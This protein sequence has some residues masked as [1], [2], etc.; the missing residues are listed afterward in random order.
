MNTITI[1]SLGPGGG[2]CLTVAAIE[3]MR[4]A[5]KLILRTDHTR[6]ADTIR[7]Q[8]MPYI[9]L[10][11]LYETADDFDALNA[12]L[13]SAV[14]AEAE[15][16]PIVY[17]VLD[18]QRDQS[19]QLL[20]EHG[21]P[22]RFVPGIGLFDPLVLAHP[23]ARVCPADTLPDS[24]GDEPL[25]IVEL[26]NAL[27]AG[28]VKLRLID[29]FGASCPCQWYTPDET[30]ERTAITIR[31]EDL[32]R[33]CAYDHTA[34]LYIAPQP[35]TEKERWTVNDLVRIMRILRQPGG[36]PWDRAQTHESLRPYL[37]EE[38][39]EVTQAIR[40]EDWLH[41]ADELGDVLLQVIFQSN[42]G[43]QYGT[44]NLSDITT[45]ICSKMIRRHPH[46]FSDVKA[47]TA[48]DVSH[49]WETI[50]RS[51]RGQ[52]S[53]AEVIDDI[54]ASLPPI[55]RAQKIQRKA[56][57]AGLLPDDSE[58]ALERISESLEV[59]RNTLRHGKD[60]QEALGELLFSCT[61]AARVIGKDS[62]TALS[63]ATDHFCKCVQTWE[64]QKN[65]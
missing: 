34:A 59:L 39:Y 44:L 28:E 8:G 38:A 37:I 43:E 3:A 63:D 11:S 26:D 15:I 46:I 45:A 12:A 33:Q 58:A 54:P 56:Q 61:N 60:T 10:D 30:P 42:I 64:K 23:D 25:L 24:L 13:I 48:D 41:V 4:A 51:E 22:L 36:C 7:N 32:D 40:E 2:E 21:A 49:N 50:K 53:L 17:A 1:I 65:T 18:A 19:V 14:E 27:L 29:W 16:C 35:L 20:R 5:P 52:K 47:K 9:S 62:E 57:A 6:V 55:M 31:L